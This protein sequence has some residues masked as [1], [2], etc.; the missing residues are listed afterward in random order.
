MNKIINELTKSIDN[1]KQSINNKYTSQNEDAPIGDNT[2]LEDYASAI[3]NIPTETVDISQQ[4][5]VFYC[6]ATNETDAKSKTKPTI[7]WN[8][9][10]NK[11]SIECKL[12]GWNTSA[13]EEELDP[14]QP[15]VEKYLYAW[16]V[17]VNTNSD[18]T[19]LPEPD[20]V[21]L[22]GKTGAKGED[23]SDGRDGVIAGMVQ[24]L[25][26]HLFK[27]VRREEDVTTELTNKPELIY[28]YTQILS[29]A[30][31][32]PKPDFLQIKN[33]LDQYVNISSTV[34][35]PGTWGLNYELPSDNPENYAVLKCV[36]NYNSLSRDVVVTDPI[37]LSGEGVVGWIEHYCITNNNTLPGDDATWTN[38]EI[39]NEFYDLGKHYLWNKTE[40]KYDSGRTVT[41][42]PVMIMSSPNAVDTIECLYG[43]SSNIS[44]EPDDWN[45]NIPDDFIVLWKK[46]TTNFT[47]GNSKVTITP[48]AVKGNPGV[49]ILAQVDKQDVKI[50]TPANM[51]G[52][53]SE[54]YYLKKG[55]VVGKD[56]YIWNGSV[57][58]DWAD[59]YENVNDTYY[60]IIIQDAFA[61]KVQAD[62]NEDDDTMP[63]YIKNRPITS[64]DWEAKV[65]TA[66]LYFTNSKIYLPVFPH[67]KVNTITL[68][69]PNGLS[70]Q[71]EYILTKDNNTCTIDGTTFTWEDSI[72]T[73]SSNV[74]VDG[75]VPMCVTMSGTQI[76]L[77]QKYVDNIIDLGDKALLK[78]LLLRNSSKLIPGSTYKF[79]YKDVEYLVDAIDSETLADTCTSK[80]HTIVVNWDFVEYYTLKN[81][82]PDSDVDISVCGRWIK[83]SW[84]DGNVFKTRYYEVETNYFCFYPG[85]NADFLELDVNRL[86][87]RGYKDRRGNEWNALYQAEV[88][89]FQEFNI[90][91]DDSCFGNKVNVYL[92]DPD[93]SSDVTVNI[94]S[95]SNNN[96]ISCY[97]TS[98]ISCNSSS[99]NTISVMNN[100][101]DVDTNNS[102][103]NNITIKYNNRLSC[104]LAMCNTVYIYGNSSEDNLV[105]LSETQCN[106]IKLYYPQSNIRVD[107]DYASCVILNESAF[108]SSDGGAGKVFASKVVT[109]S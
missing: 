81:R 34:N 24:Y 39:P 2:L 57:E 83:F 109:L 94:T 71:N 100:S 89:M 54:E 87:V 12:G 8:S 29:E 13:D 21:R 33:S 23:G 9:S 102:D 36:A 59:E 31:R 76:R 68:S 22:T 106:L 11:W 67:V 6:W 40:I 105:R 60:W 28:D 18:N 99:S 56:L 66:D 41:T 101:Y 61:T 64:N 62:W 42:T 38:N 58:P 3:D 52:F 93:T 43:Q 69:L 78:I 80:S 14:N 27:I 96:I 30:N 70:G 73:A 48:I 75:P 50:W 37:M 17:S 107:E 108:S 91:F 1:I 44:T 53:N 20:P 16:F 47:I 4:I 98:S 82:P 90:S 25:A 26:A 72:I 15:N 19:G 49:D 86:D 55:I 74:F 92:T 104:S 97:N 7:T 51:A 63:G 45:E 95:G 84:Q 46:E 65:C 32:H 85:T 5:F 88:T 79:T 77:S 10:A 35:T 103:L